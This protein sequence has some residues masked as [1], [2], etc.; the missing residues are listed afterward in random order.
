MSEG[1]NRNEG[2]L[3]ADDVF[4]WPEQEGLWRPGMPE[5]SKYLAYLK[6]RGGLDDPY[7][8][9]EVEEFYSLDYAYAEVMLT[10]PHSGTR[11]VGMDGEKTI[12]RIRIEGGFVDPALRRFR[13]MELAARKFN[14]LGG[15]TGSQ[16]N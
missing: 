2:L 11:P 7:V 9:A 4:L 15:F 3:T 13:V 5:Y 10:G 14:L 8:L 1:I 6:G 16:D 12:K